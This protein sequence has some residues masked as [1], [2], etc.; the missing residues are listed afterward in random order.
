MK[1]PDVAPLVGAWIEI[2]SVGVWVSVFGVAP[3][4]GAWIEISES[5]NEAIVV[6][7]VA[8]LVGAWIEIVPC[9]HQTGRTHV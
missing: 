2:N 9:S 6:L 5:Y 8:P 3:L 1:V 4:V 7:L